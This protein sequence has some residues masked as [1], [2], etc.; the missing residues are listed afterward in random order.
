[1]E[2]TDV[3]V[4]RIESEG[5]L[6]AYATIT[7]DNQF[8]IHNLKVIDG[9]AGLFVAMP[10]RKTKSGVFKDVAH[11]IS[12]DFRTELQDI[13]LKAYELAPLTPADGEPLLDDSEE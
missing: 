7:F 11:P 6:R 8:V 1:M 3:R 5:K 10:S 13:I 9:K 4:R 12:S 2:I